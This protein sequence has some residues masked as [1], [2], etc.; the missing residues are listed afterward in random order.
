MKE[1]RMCLCFKSSFLAW[2][3]FYS[4]F[5]LATLRILNNHATLDLISRQLRR[6]CDTDLS[7][8][9]SAWQ[10]NSNGFVVNICFQIYLFLLLRAQANQMLLI[11][12]RRRG[13][14]REGSTRRSAI[15]LIISYSRQVDDIT[16]LWTVLIDSP[17]RSFDVQVIFSFQISWIRFFLSSTSV[18]NQVNSN[19]FSLKWARSIWFVVIQH[20]IITVRQWIDL[21]A[22][23]W[24]YPAE[25]I[26]KKL[27]DEAGGPL[28]DLYILGGGK[29]KVDFDQKKINL[30][31]QSEVSEQ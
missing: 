29:I 12:V 17:N 31:D 20:S 16:S 5:N 28:N 19:T 3:L 30:F 18:R 13:N 27:Q 21:E 14:G 7:C 23:W 24:F 9:A 6:I 2:D 15:S 11:L 25:K 22:D 8:F 10:I 4:F 26:F 1:N